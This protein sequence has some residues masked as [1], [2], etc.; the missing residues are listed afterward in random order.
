MP[1]RTAPL[2]IGA[3]VATLPRARPGVVGFTVGVAQPDLVVRARRR[4]GG[5]LV[6]RPWSAGFSSRRAGQNIGFSVTPWKIH[7]ELS[8]MNVGQRRMTK[9]QGRL[10]EGGRNGP[11]TLP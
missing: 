6:H 11:A 2:P 8:R 5:T 1:I 7:D 10:P 9:P 4:P 3:D